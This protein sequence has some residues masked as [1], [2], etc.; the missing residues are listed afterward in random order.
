MPTLTVQRDKGWADKIRKYRILLDGVEIGRIGEGEVLRQQISDGP[1]AIEAKIDWCGS[2]PLHF[3]AQSE[4]QVVVVRSAL[5]GWR[6][7]LGIFYVF[8]NRRGYLLLE[9]TQ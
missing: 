3:N 9:L 2:R 7:L 4:D 8:F 1:H 5:R 6:L